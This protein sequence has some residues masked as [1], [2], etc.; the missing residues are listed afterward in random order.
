MAQL[1]VKCPRGFISW[2]ECLG[3]CAHDPLRPCD[4]TADLLNMMNPGNSEEPDDTAFSP[5]R[6][7]GC[8]RQRVLVGEHDYYVDVDQA[9]P[10][11]RGNM[12]HALM[13]A[14]QY[15]GA[16]HVI[17]EE[18]F[19]VQ[20]ETPYGVQDFSAKPDLIVVKDIVPDDSPDFYENDADVP[21]V[22]YVKIIDYKSIVKVDN[23]LDEPKLEHQLQV[24]MYAWLVTQCLPLYLGI[25][26]LRVEV[27]ELEILYCS[28]DGKRRFTS[29][30][31]R[32]I[33]TKRRIN[34]RMEESTIELQ[35]IRRWKLDATGRYI[36]AKII[37]RLEA[38]HVKLPDILEGEQAWLCR[39]CPVYDVCHQ[40]GNV[41]EEDEA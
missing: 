31:S 21:T 8:A 41:T 39:Y 14:A 38:Q 29:A 11:T 7:L 26:N 4:Y 3:V 9:Y 12:V 16:V 37:E 15:P 23:S 20:I 10:A 40:I 17:R 5:T 24:N 27:D 34:G 13:E 36:Q 32:V 25:P 19:R 33:P 1:G 22:A 2:T 28:M 35:P 30:G 6:L 18:R